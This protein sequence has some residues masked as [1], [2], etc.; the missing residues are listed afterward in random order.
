MKSS[1]IKV[2]MFVWLFSSIVI[3]L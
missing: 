3:I 2:K 1:T